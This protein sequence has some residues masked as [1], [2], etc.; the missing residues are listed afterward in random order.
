MTTEIRS[1]IA[2]TVELPAGVD[3]LTD[4]SDLYEAGMT[5]FGSVQLMLALEEA[6]DVE[7]PERMLNRKLFS[8]VTSISAALNELVAER[9]EG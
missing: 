3:S 4:T 1:I 5:S 7:F 6:F 9:A 2:R 8:S